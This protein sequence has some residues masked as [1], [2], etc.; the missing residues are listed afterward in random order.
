VTATKRLRAAPGPALITA[1]P[2]K[3]RPSRALGRCALR[4]V[5]AKRDTV[6]LIGVSGG[7]RQSYVV[8]RL[9]RPPSRGDQRCL[10]IHAWTRSGWIDQ[11]QSVFR[12]KL[13]PVMFEVET[14]LAAVRAVNWSHRDWKAQLGDPGG[15]GLAT[16]LALHTMMSSHK[17]CFGTSKPIFR[18]RRDGSHS[19]NPFQP[20]PQGVARFWPL[21]RR[22]R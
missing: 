10:P 20:G 18:L 11:R 2:T 5:V 14:L 16:H 15:D 22:E 1:D 19:L 12:V 6:G 17:G 9:R 8:W 4:R 13:D 21:G 7:V 3:I